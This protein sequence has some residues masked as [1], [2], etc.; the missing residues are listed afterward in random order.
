MS[1]GNGQ[2]STKDRPTGAMPSQSAGPVKENVG[3]STGS[4][5]EKA[6]GAGSELVTPEGRTKIADGVVAKIAGMAARDIGGVHAM[7]AGM[8]RRMG[9]VKERLPGGMGGQNV[10][11]GVAVQVG[12]RQAA[13][14]IDLVV[15]YG[16]AIPQ[17]AQAVRSNVIK[18]VEHACGLEVVEVNITVDD[19]HVPGE[20]DDSEE[21]PSEPRVR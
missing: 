21:E 3:H 2:A 20:T 14:D 11:Q 12:E 7:G 16:A 1:H 9:S 5:L 19:I 17:L 6:G 18:E 13:I 4:G 10:M 8:A 15:E